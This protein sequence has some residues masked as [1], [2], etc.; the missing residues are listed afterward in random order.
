M[1]RTASAP[2]ENPAV[3]ERPPRAEQGHGGES[4][5]W[6]PPS[7]LA[8]ADLDRDAAIQAR[9]SAL[10]PGLAQHH[11][12]SV[13]FADQVRRAVQTHLGDPGDPDDNHGLAAL[14]SSAPGGLSQRQ[15]RLAKAYLTGQPLQRL[16]V[17][18]IAVACGLSRSHFSKA[19]KVTT[20]EAPHRWAMQYRLQQAIHLLGGEKPMADIARACGFADQSHMSRSFR[21][22]VGVSPT[23]WRR[24][25][26]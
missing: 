3:P 8:A 6:T 7:A 26:G 2:P 12:A 23:T 13:Q 21:R 24:Q 18:K 20:G 15:E 19:F 22:E 25:Q 17:E 9:V 11:F 1:K 5:V 4:E 16:S 10:L 14:S